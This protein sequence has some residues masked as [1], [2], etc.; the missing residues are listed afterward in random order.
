MCSYIEKFSSPAREK[1]ANKERR[2]MAAVL[3]DA[4]LLQTR[5]LQGRDLVMYILY[6]LLL[7]YTV[8]NK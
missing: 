6:V 4:G 1:K 5:Q 2:N 3:K 7:S 8:L